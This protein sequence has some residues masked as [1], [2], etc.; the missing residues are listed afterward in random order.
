MSR[1]PTSHPGQETTMSTQTQ[2]TGQL[3]PTLETSA[4]APRRRPA[5]RT[6][7][8]SVMAG[9]VSALVLVFVVFAGG[10]EVTITG[11][12]LLGFGFGWALIATL[13]VRRTRQ[14]QRWTVVPAVTMGATGAALVV[15]SPGSETMTAVNWVWP[16]LMLALTT[17]MSLQVRRSVTGKARWVITPVIAVLTLA[18]LGATYENIAPTNDTTYAAPGNLYD[19]GGHQLHLDCQGQGSP[20]VVLSNSLGGVSA[21]WARITGPV[22]ESTRVCAYDR[23]GQGWSEEAESP[24]DGVQ[25]AEELHALLAAAGEE[26]PHVLVGHSTGGTYAMTYAARY[27]KQVAGLVL[28]DSSSPEQFTAM[29]AFEGQYAVMRRAYALLPTLS[30]LGLG[31]LVPATSQL[32]AA[33]A[34]KVEAITST[35]QGYRNQRDDVS[36]LPGLFTQA[37]ALT[38]LGDR[39]LAVLTASENSTATEGW[40]DAQHQLV[41]LSTNGIHRTVESTHTGLL[42]DAGP[43]AESVRAITEII[44][45]VRSGRPLPAS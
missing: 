36:V 7:V 2:A 29:P 12:L 1:S 26:G 15:L 38:T 19:V 31:R 21:G 44:S 13:T 14:P 18:S 3:R 11:A 24:R 41:G 20:T 4:D 28:L 9:A 39:P 10:T 33:D 5:G 23:A 40:A 30:R 27:P 16:P 22:A 42:E 43:A 34:A 37:Q 25:S 32:P 35:S 6:I 45:V 17:W 8:L